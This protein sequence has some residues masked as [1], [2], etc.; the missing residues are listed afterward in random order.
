MQVKA[1]LRSNIAKN[2]I[3]MKEQK[4]FKNNNN[5]DYFNNN[6][7]DLTEPFISRH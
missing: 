1:N 2:N 5:N 4:E 6:E 3:I 7:N